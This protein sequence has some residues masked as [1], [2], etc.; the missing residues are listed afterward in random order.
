LGSPVVVKVDAVPYTT[1][2]PS[3][4]LVVPYFA[5]GWKLDDPLGVTES[6]SVLRK[7]MRKLKRISE[8]FTSHDASPFKAW[9]GKLA[10][11][12]V[13]NSAKSVQND[14][15]GRQQETLELR[16]KLVVL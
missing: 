6:A 1:S 5:S 15:D 7:S 2:V 11:G 14:R 12:I 16:I 4:K 8:K 3:Q 10:K 9:T 13:G